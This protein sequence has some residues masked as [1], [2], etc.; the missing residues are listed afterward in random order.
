MSSYQHVIAI[1]YFF[2][3]IIML[4]LFLFYLT[5]YTFDR[6]FKGEKMV[7]KFFTEAGT[8]MNVDLEM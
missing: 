4:F 7:L 3:K 2:V 8:I 5:G 6:S 1:Y